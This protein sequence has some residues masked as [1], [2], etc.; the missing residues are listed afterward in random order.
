MSDYNAADT[1]AI[2]RAAKLAKQLDSEHQTVVYGTM[3]S[4]AGRNYIHSWLERCHVFSSSYGSSALGMAFAEGERN[5]GL[6][7]LADIMRWAP[8]QYLQMMREAN[9]RSSASS[10]P[11]GSDP[12]R[13]RNGDDSRPEPDGAGAGAISDYEPGAFDDVG[14]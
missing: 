11:S 9:D 4:P 14:V 2:R 10:R 1:R 13:G 5:I 12:Q 7:L 8:D 3:A 6:Q